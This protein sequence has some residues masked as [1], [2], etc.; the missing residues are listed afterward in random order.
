MWV[1]RSEYENLKADIRR[2]E[3]AVKY[4]ETPQAI[5]ALLR[6]LRLD[7]VPGRAGYTPPR[8]EPWPKDAKA[9]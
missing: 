5:A 8:V 2:L 7:F 3:T 1:R 9:K 6:H 4:G